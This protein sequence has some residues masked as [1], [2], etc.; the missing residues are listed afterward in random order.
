M[1]KECFTIFQEKVTDEVLSKFS[2]ELIKEFPRRYQ[3]MTRHIH[4]N[5]EI[6]KKNPKKS[7]IF[8]TRISKEIVVG[9]SKQWSSF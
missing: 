5:S 3:R 7:S 1:F 4:E 2:E 9:S 8:F 6:P